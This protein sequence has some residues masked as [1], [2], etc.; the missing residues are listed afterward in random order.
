MS[1]NNLMCF[2]MPIAERTCVCAC[3]C[4]CVCARVRVRMCVCIVCERHINKL[5]LHCRRPEMATMSSPLLI[6][7]GLSLWWVTSAQVALYLSVTHD[8]ALTCSMEGFHR[9]EH[10]LFF[11][12]IVKRG[13]QEDGRDAVLATVDHS[14]T[15]ASDFL[16]AAHPGHQLSG[17][18]PPHRMSDSRLKL[19]LFN[20]SYNHGDGRYVC[21][22]T[23]TDHPADPILSNWT[24][25]ELYVNTTQANMP[26]EE[27]PGLRVEHK[28]G[29]SAK[30]VARMSVTDMRI[31]KK[32]G[33]PLPRTDI[34]RSDDQAYLEAHI[35]DVECNDA[36]Q[37][38]CGA[39]DISG[40]TF[41]SSLRPLP[42]DD[43]PVTTGK[44]N[45][46]DGETQN[47]STMTVV[48]I[49]LGCVLVLVVVVVFLAVFI[50]KKRK[51]RSASEKSPRS[52][53]KKPETDGPPDGATIE[54]SD[55]LHPRSDNDDTDHHDDHYIHARSTLV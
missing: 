33:N 41:N 52:G 1:S 13:A 51:R 54:Q 43:C 18:I 47:I 45:D 3:V 14:E 44:T 7:L 34:K 46:R 12:E 8:V 30:C 11:L 17:E 27:V 15:R 29:V 49:V 20:I 39:T 50:V 24:S 36:S 40:L 37:Y 28:R 19:T 10:R 42:R 53:K 32:D 21:R 55:N 9:R 6:C 48:A 35:Q 5:S 38:F 31:S 22:I 23:Y 2:S 4:V 25:E 26:P 16:N